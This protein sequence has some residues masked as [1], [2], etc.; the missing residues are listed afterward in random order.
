[1]RAWPVIVNML[2]CYISA[3]TEN[4]FHFPDISWTLTNFPLPFNEFPKENT[5]EIPEYISR[6]TLDPINC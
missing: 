5:L 6:K 4:P 2:R 3:V 1:M